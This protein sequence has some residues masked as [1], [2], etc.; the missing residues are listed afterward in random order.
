VNS[1]AFLTCEVVMP[2]WMGAAWRGAVAL[3]AGGAL[4]SIDGSFA[5][6]SGI[7]SFFRAKGLVRFCMVTSFSLP[8]LDT[9]QLVRLDY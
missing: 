5:T 2:L 6:S 3:A 1:D 4:T 7:A 9:G 8:R